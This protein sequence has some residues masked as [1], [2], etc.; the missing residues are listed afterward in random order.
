MAEVKISEEKIAQ[1]KITD[2]SIVEKKT[3][4]LMMLLDLEIDE[5]HYQKFV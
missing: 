4:V 5:E 2:A 3:F 1:K